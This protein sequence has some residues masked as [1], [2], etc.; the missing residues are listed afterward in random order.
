MIDLD[1][2]PQFIVVTDAEG[3]HG[4]LW[5]VQCEV[6]KQQLIGALPADEEPVPD[7]NLVDDAQPQ[8]DFF[9]FG[10]VAP[11]QVV[12]MAEEAAAEGNVGGNLNWALW[13]VEQNVA[14]AVLAPDNQ[15]Q[16]DA[17]NGS[18]VV[19]DDDSDDSVNM[20]PD[21][22]AP[23]V[24]VEDENV[25]EVNQLNQEEKLDQLPVPMEMDI[26]PVNFLPEE[27]DLNQLMDPQEEEDNHGGQDEEQM[28]SLQQA[29]HIPELQLMEPPH[30]EDAEQPVNDN[31]FVGFMQT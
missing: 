12:N 26:E 19:S 14:P 4:H 2:V 20:M 9:G 25:P 28:I 21:L 31:I 24:I 23:N 18:G 22:N 30:Q 10:Q 13:P 7:L 27:I 16:P 3:F 17:D 11:L 6:I 29:D 5:T 1:R 15:P 8:F